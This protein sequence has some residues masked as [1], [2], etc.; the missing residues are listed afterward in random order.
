MAGAAYSTA[1]LRQRLRTGMVIPAHPLALDANRKLDEKYQ[2]ALTRYYLAAGSGGL[3][4]GVHTTQFAIRDEKVGLFKP[5]L[6]LAAETSKQFSAETKREVF[7]VAG[8]CGKTAQAVAEARLAKDLDYHIGL[9]SLGAMKDASDAELVAHAKAVSE[10]IPVMGFYLQPSVGGRLLSAD[11]WRAF[12][13]IENVIA[14]KMAPFNRYQTIDVIRGVAEAGRADDIV[15]YTGNDDNIVL[16]LLTKYEFAVKGRPV[17]LRIHGGLLGHW[18]VWTKKAV[19]LMADVKKIIKDNQP[20]PP[21]ML[22]R[23]IQVTDSNAAFF[24]PSHGFHGCIAGLHEVLVRQGL[25]QGRWCLDPHED[26]SPGQKEEIDR[27]Y[28]AYPHLHDDVFVAENRDK[29]LK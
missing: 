18:S 10:V 15:L 27:V 12:A 17:S 21:A 28:A 14:I 22:T 2:R 16:D 4:V 8:I 3:A 23:A 5:V 11:F 6:Q 1:Q 19:D 20:I 7:R 9:L 26:L 13:A 29:W 25:L 24:D